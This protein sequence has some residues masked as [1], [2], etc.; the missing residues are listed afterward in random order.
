MRAQSQSQSRQLA[1]RPPT[2]QG[3]VWMITLHERAGMQDDRLATPARIRDEGWL[4]VPL[5]PNLDPDSHAGRL[6]RSMRR[7]R[8]VDDPS[9]W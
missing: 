8:W 3:E 6:H 1:Q 4:E 7:W 2:A 9:H 5:E